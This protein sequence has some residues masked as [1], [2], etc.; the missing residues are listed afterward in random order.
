MEKRTGNNDERPDL[1][2]VRSDVELL[3]VFEPN[4]HR[5]EDSYRLVVLGDDSPVDSL[6]LQEKHDLADNFSG[7]VRIRIR[8]ARWVPCGKPKPGQEAG[9]TPSPQPTPARPPEET[10]QPPRPP[11]PPEQPPS[12]PEKG[13]DPY[14]V[15]GNTVEQDQANREDKGTGGTAGGEDTKPN[16]P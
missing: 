5:V 2:D 12:P 15:P 16:E 4:A 8:R 10:P 11:S 3:V 13:P 9:P 7:D 6:R 14:H 1:V